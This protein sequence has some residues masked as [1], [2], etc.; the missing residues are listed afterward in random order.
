MTF[1]SNHHQ[2]RQQVTW[3]HTQPTTR[4]RI[5]SFEDDKGMYQTYP[6]NAYKM[7]RRLCT[8]TH[9]VV[10]KVKVWDFS[11]SRCYSGSPRSFHS[12]WSKGK[13]NLSH[14][15]G[16][17][18]VE[19]RPLKIKVCTSGLGRWLRDWRWETTELHIASHCT[20]PFRPL[21]LWGQPPTVGLFK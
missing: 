17:L 8:G 3:D 1:K 16:I 13:S 5:R 9:T 20:T 10:F 12:L 6:K 11:N 18:R 21:S 14:A 2:Y 4:K 7:Y 15:A 19:G